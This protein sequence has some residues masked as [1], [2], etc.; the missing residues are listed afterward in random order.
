[1]S[2]KRSF[3]PGE[4][5]LYFKLYCS[6]R[7]ADNILV[8]GILPFI[9]ELRDRNHIQNW[10]YIRYRDP[11][12]HL[13]LRIRKRSETSIDQ[14]TRALLIHLESSIHYEFIHSIQ[15]DTYDREME[16]YG[17]DTIE[18]CEE[19]FRIDSELLANI[20]SLNIHDKLLTC[21]A[22]YIIETY[23]DIFQFTHKD[24]IEYIS[25]KR[26]QF[27]TEFGIVGKRKSAFRLKYSL[28]SELIQK[29][30]SELSQLSLL[31]TIFSQTKLDME[32][33]AKKILAINND[34]T[35]IY[36]SIVPSLIH[37]SMNRM[38]RDEQRLFEAMC[39]DF[40]LRKLKNST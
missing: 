31:M 38:Y 21:V 30:I 28:H 29:K 14:I 27:Y 40:L 13:R 2:T 37:M 24:K 7:T 33:I 10:F 23:L 15:I 11:K 5:W 9:T 16:R 8:K 4:E 39:Y 3:Y 19:M 36:D 6:P 17:E 22:L 35:F 12:Y 26:K 20:A 32:H 34:K 25:A 18:L 1:M